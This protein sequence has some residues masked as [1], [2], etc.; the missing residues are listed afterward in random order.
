MLSGSDTSLI[1]PASTAL[2]EPLHAWLEKRLE[3]WQPLRPGR[4]SVDAS[5]NRRWRLLVDEPLG[6]S[7]VIP[8]AHIT[9]WRATAAAGIIRLTAG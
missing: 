1:A 5:E 3:R 7:R 9:A 8:Q 2:A 4:Q 6:D